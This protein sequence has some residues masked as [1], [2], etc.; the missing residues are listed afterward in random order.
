MKYYIYRISTEHGTQ[1]TVPSLFSARQELLETSNNSSGE[2]IELLESEE[3]AMEYQQ[4]SDV[5]GDS[6]DEGLGDISSDDTIEL[7]VE[8]SVESQ[9]SDINEICQQQA[10]EISAKT[11]KNEKERRPSRISF[12]TPL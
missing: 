1:A 8:E 3:E 10:I 5:D 9:E 7:L 12:E 11:P 2:V 6:L 4:S